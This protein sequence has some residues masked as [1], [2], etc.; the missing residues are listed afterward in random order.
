MNV[1]ITERDNSLINLI[2]KYGCIKLNDLI[3]YFFKSKW[4]GYKR[5]EKLVKANYLYKDNSKCITLGVAGKKFLKKKGSTLYYEKISNERKINVSS[6][7]E[8]MRIFES[9][10]KTIS[11]AE[12]PA[13]QKDSSDNLT[14]S[15]YVV[16]IYGMVIDNFGDE[17]SVYKISKNTQKVYMK[18]VKSDISKKKNAIIFFEREKEL[19]VYRKMNANR[20]ILNKELLYLLDDKGIENAKMMLR[21]QLRNENII[22]LFRD[23]L[24]RKGKYLYFNDQ[25]VFNLL[26][27]NFI[28][29]NRVASLSTKGKKQVIVFDNNTKII[30]KRYINSFDFI[31]V[32]IDEYKEM[33]RN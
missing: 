27:N 11:R 17:Y 18:K 19:N 23:K 12:I 32:N 20:G 33:L 10:F 28:T 22:R 8:V 9:E 6:I 2:N 31:E 14:Q 29:E 3:K 24:I 21:G 15:D 1:D 30:D 26:D 4:V 5:I 25:V 16:L 7:Y 13:K